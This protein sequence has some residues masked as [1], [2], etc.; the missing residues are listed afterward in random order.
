VE[1]LKTSDLEGVVK[2]LQSKNIKYNKQYYSQVERR[3]PRAVNEDEIDDPRTLADIQQENID[4]KEQT[5]Q[6]MLVLEQ[7]LH[8]AHLWLEH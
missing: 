3:D 4:L 1:G 2:T 5:L 6:Q 8:V 7:Y